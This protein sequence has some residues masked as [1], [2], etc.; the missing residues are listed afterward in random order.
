MAGDC[1]R[2]ACFNAAALIEANGWKC[3]PG[4]ATALTAVCDVGGHVGVV[5]FEG[6]SRGPGGKRGV[7]LG[8][9]VCCWSGLLEK[10]FSEDKY[11]L[12]VLL[13]DDDDGRRWLPC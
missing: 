12:F 1:A 6:R 5:N 7:D 13:A 2:P 4:P 11:D 3:D 10:G 9:R 8:Q